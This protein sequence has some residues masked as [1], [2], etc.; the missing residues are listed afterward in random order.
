MKVVNSSGKRKRAIA[1]ATIKEGKGSVRINRL[2]LDIYEPKLARM[3][4]REP[5]QIA[6]RIADKVDIS[7]KIK[8]GGF[9]SQA[10]AGRLAIAR[11]LVEW[12]GD[13]K[14]KSDF[15][16]YD[17]WLLVG[18]TRHREMRKPNRHGKARA[19]VQKSY[20]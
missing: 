16:N 7:V 9:M 18:D 20:R 14:L 1:R 11:A 4:L 17:R 5:L 15:E 2:P 3:K 13:S 19:K 10:E 12:S 6:G 8:G